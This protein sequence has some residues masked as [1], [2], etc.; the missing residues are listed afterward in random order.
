M[1]V[2]WLINT[3]VPKDTIYKGNLLGWSTSRRILNKLDRHKWQ[4]GR[5]GSSF[6]KQKADENG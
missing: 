5:V 1:R 3:G 6:F 2:T 4:R